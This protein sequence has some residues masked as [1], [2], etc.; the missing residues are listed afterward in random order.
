MRLGRRKEAVAGW[1]FI[2]PCLIGFLVFMLY[3]LLYTSFLSLW[4]WNFYQGVNGSD[5]VGI[6]NF[7][8]VIKNEYFLTG[9]QNNFTIFVIAVPILLLLALVLASIL[10]SAVFCRGILRTA[11]FMPYVTTV[12]AS[13][14]VFSALLHADYGPVNEVLRAIGISNPPGWITSSDW[15]V[16]TVAMFWIWRMLGYCVVIFLSGL[17][18]ISS[19][20]YEAS[21]IDGAN[22][23]QK[24]WKITFPLISPTTFFLA[25]TMSIFSFSLF[26]ESQVLT[27]G[28]PGTS[29]YTIVFH[30][31]TSA[32]VNFEMG[33]AAAVSL[34]FFGIIL[35]ITLLQWFGQKKWVNY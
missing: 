31:Y 33:Y 35:V 12:T 24:F 10:N 7:T 29:S 28:G 3:P 20:Y 21:D 30:I 13:A 4:D 9:L 2:L 5:F 32:F 27:D 34:V 11:Y 15:S 22:T 18:G 16:V 8:D 23:W 19:S 17:Q 14:I 6:E 25:V 26:A 1:L